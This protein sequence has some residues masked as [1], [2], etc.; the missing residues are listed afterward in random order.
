MDRTWTGRERFGRG[1]Q[2]RGPFE[3]PGGLFGEDQNRARAA[4]RF[5][6]LSIEAR[7]PANRCD[8]RLET[9]PPLRNR[10]DERGVLSRVAQ[11]LAEREDVVR[12][13]RFLHEGV[14]PHL[15]EELFFR[16]QPALL[17]DQCHEQVDGLRCQWHRLVVQPQQ[18][19]SRVERKRP[20]LKR[21][22]VVQACVRRLMQGYQ[23]PA[24]VR[25][26]LKD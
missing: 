4:R 2:D 24:K 22:E 9:I 17:F 12:Q 1:F 5:A 19:L 23:L 21:G 6:R 8:R 16:N 14:R 10:F 15:L 18:S 20:E 26:L 7:A 13:V 3:L 25:K 11:R